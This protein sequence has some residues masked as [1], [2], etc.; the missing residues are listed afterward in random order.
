MYNKQLLL[1]D[2]FPPLNCK[3]FDQ[4]RTEIVVPDIR[5]LDQSL[6]KKRLAKHFQHNDS[7]R[8]TGFDAFPQNDIILGCQQYIDNLISKKGLDGLQIFEH[9]YHYYKKLN[10]KIKYVTVD[11][12]ESK[13]P[14]LIAMPFPGHLQTHRQMEEIL[15]VC[16]SKSIDVHIDCAWLSAAFDI[17]FNF[18]R[19]CVKSFAMSFSKSYHL[20]WNKIGIR[21]SRITDNSDAITIQNNVG[22]ISNFNLYVAGKYMEKFPID[23][24]CKKYKDEYFKIC[25][26]LKLRPSNIIH[27]CFSIDRKFLYGLK[28]FFY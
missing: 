11:T 7:N 15:E 5:H 17:N 24:L 26:T 10:T 28:N 27:A 14:L 9:D 3:E 25:R 16:E 20:H 6:F 12:L 13:K 21:W 2:Y 18:D 19:P 1:E 8:L 22:G 23:H 4:L